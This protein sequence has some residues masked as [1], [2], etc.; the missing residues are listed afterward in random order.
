MLRRTILGQ[1][2]A[3]DPLPTKSDKL[4]VS[5]PQQTDLRFIRTDAEEWRIKTADVFF[6]EVPSTAV[7]L[8]G[9]SVLAHNLYRQTL[10]AARLGSLWVPE[11]VRIDSVLRNLRPRVSAPTAHIPK[12]LRAGSIPRT[13]ERDTNDSYWQD[14]GSKLGLYSCR[15]GMLIRSHVSDGS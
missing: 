4:P 13:T 1:V 14:R 5:G 11:A 15:I 8:L 10:Y 3:E 6:Q 9:I 2:V 7:E 12:L